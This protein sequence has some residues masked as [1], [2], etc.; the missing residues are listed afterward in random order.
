MRVPAPKHAL[1][2]L[3]ALCLLTIPGCLFGSKTKTSFRGQYINQQTYSRLQ[4]GASEE[5]V[6]KLFGEPTTKTKSHSKA[7]CLTESCLF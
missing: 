7:N 5:D 4:P 6:Y 3:A 2:A 1:A